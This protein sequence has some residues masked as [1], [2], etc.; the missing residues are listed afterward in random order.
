MLRPVLYVNA[1]HRFAKGT[2]GFETGVAEFEA[3]LVFAFC[4]ECVVAL[5]AGRE[6]RTLA[7]FC[8]VNFWMD[9]ERVHKFPHM[10][11]GACEMLDWNICSGGRERT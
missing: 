2:K 1:D 4:L 3:E 5:V 11:I 9:L 7:L 6:R 8:Y 10:S